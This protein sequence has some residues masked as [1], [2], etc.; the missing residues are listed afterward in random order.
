MLNGS[1]RAGPKQKRYICTGG[2]VDTTHPSTFK[3]AYRPD[4]LRNDDDT[5]PE[6]PSKSPLKKKVRRIVER[7]GNPR[8]RL[9]D[10]EYDA[11]GAC[12]GAGADHDYDD[13][14]TSFNNKSEDDSTSYKIAENE[15]K[16]EEGV[17]SRVKSTSNALFLD[18]VIERVLRANHGD[19]HDV[20]IHTVECLVAMFAQS[21][22]KS[23]LSVR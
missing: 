7:L 3:A 8:R 13:S 18:S 10:L 17:G 15:G 9:L 23:F 2:H 14:S 5:K 21:S 20:Q 6:S 16:Q 1:K 22:V 11:A 4:N 12:A 19:K